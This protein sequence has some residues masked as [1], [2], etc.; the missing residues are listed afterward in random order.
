MTRRL[1]TLWKTQPGVLLQRCVWKIQQSRYEKKP[2][3]Q[4]ICCGSCCGVDLKLTLTFCPKM[5]TSVTR[6]RENIF[7]KFEVFMTCRSGLM[8]ERNGQTDGRI[9]L[10]NTHRKEVGAHVAAEYTIFIQCSHMSRHWC[11]VFDDKVGQLQIK[12]NIAICDVITAYVLPSITAAGMRRKLS[13]DDSILCP[14]SKPTDLQLLIC[15][16]VPAL[17]WGEA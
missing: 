2:F 5:K 14:A 9:T 8:T 6:A 10:H 17:G 13:N 12:R 4:H 11:I 15:N 1:F 3:C 7:T 16:S